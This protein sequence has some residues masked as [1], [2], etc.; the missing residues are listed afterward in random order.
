M[1]PL[2]RK[3]KISTW[4]YVGLV[5]IL[6]EIMYYYKVGI[7]NRFF[8]TTFYYII[9]YGLLTFLGVSYK[10]LSNKKKMAI[11]II[12]GVTFFSLLMYLWYQNGAIQNVQIAKYPPRIYYLSYGVFVSFLSLGLCKAFPLKIFSNKVLQFISRQSMWIYLWHI[13][14]L[15]VYSVLRLPEIWYIKFAIIYLVSITMTFVINKLLDI[16]DRNKKIHFFEYLRS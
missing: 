4:V 12:S 11:I 7:N 16:I 8:D 9:P 3:I 2:F 1:I 14:M 5:Y 15:E 13:L 10:I 6:Y